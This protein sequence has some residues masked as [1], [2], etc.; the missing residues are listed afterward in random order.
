MVSLNNAD[1]GVSSFANSG[2]Q[3]LQV[4]ELA[5]GGF[6]LLWKNSND[7]YA[8]WELDQSGAY[9]TSY[10]VDPAEV[11]V[12]FDADIDGD[13]NI[14]PAFASLF[15]GIGAAAVVN[16]AKFEGYAPT[17]SNGSALIQ[18]QT[19]TVER[20]PDLQAPPSAPLEVEFAFNTAP[21][22]LPPTAPEATPPA[23]VTTPPRDGEPFEPAPAPTALVRPAPEPD[24][25]I[26]AD[27]FIF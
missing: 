15:A 2:W 21:D 7:I 8:I 10:V 11:E 1:V 3:A 27:D 6:Q 18:D 24:P 17:P 14:G 12:T 13:G 20:L 9:Q 16:E 19:A 5:N 22:Q 25:G 26:N 4:E 23:P